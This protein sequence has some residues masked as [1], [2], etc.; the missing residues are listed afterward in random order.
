M[1][2]V[3]KREGKKGVTWCISYYVNGKQVR[4]TVGHH[5]NGVTERQAKEALKSREGAIVQ[6]KFDIAQTKVSPL[7]SKVMK[8]YL[9]WSRSNK[10]AYKRDITSSKHLLPFFGNK[11]LDEV[12]K[13]LIERYRMKRKAEIMVKYP[14]KAENDI[15]FAS[16][17][18][19][20]ALLKHFYT[21]A[22]EWG[23]AE[24]NPAKGIKMHKE[25]GKERYLEEEE[26][27]AFLA[28]CKNSSNK[29]LLAMVETALNAGMRIGEVF[30]LK[31]SDLDFKNGII[32]LE[33]T[34]NG[35][36]GKVPMSDYLKDSLQEHIKGH[37]FE[38]VFCKKDGSPFKD[39]RFALSK[40]LKEAGIKDCTFHTLRH[41]FASH[42]AINGVDLYTLQELGRW[43]TL[44][45]VKKY[46][47]LSPHH[48]KTAVNKLN[49][50]FS[51]KNISGNTLVE[52]KFGRAEENA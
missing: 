52:G 18:R 15:S 34:K 23:K 41:T 20:M 39:I 22:I 36:R 40:A 12:N 5:K 35:E 6:G 51:D 30:R 49:G 11:R 44:N 25:K 37:S 38:Y 16:I 2:S 14:K 24:I 13:W 19:E 8:E 48:K 31:V 9:E 3:Y 26:V 43:K 10:K 17:N 21:K 27:A 33:D 7:F 47:H 42:L 32:N 46:A 28:A 29:S 1:G 4:E 45:M 50:L